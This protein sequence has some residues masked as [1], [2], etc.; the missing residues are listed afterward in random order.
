[1]S[2][3]A[4]IANV[5]ESTVASLMTQIGQ[6]CEKFLPNRVRQVKISHLESDEIWAF[7]WKKQKKANSRLVGYTFAG[8]RTYWLAFVEGFS[9]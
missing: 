1:M 6:G 8:S 2:S 5:Q 7:V 3:T 9:P 4:R